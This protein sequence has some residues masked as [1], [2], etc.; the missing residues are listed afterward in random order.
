MGNAIVKLVKKV[1]KLEGFMKRRNL[2]LTDSEEE[3]PE[4]QGRKSQDDPLDSSVQGLLSFPTT[5]VKHSGR[6][7]CPLTRDGDYKRRK[8]L[9]KESSSSF[10]IFKKKLIWYE[11]VNTTMAEQTKTP[12]RLKDDKDVGAKDD[13]PTKKF[14]RRK[15]MARKGMHTSV[16]K[17]DSEDSDEVGEHEES[18]TG[19]ET[20]I[21]LVHVAIKNNLVVHC[22]NLESMD[23]YM[24][25][26]RKY[27]LSAEMVGHFTKVDGISNSPSFMY[28]ELTIGYHPTMELTF[29][30]CKGLTSPEQMFFTAKLTH[31]VTQQTSAVTTAMTAILKQFQA[32]P[33]PASVKAVEEI[34]VT[35]GGA[36]PYYQCLA[37][38][39]NT[40]PEYQDNIQGYVSAATG[41]YNQGNSCYRPPGLAN[42]TRPPGLVQQNGQNN[43]NRFSQPQG[44]NR[45]NNFNQNPTYQAPIQQNQSVPLS[46]LEKIKKIND[47]NI[48][49]QAAH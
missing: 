39:G 20:T 19:L 3:E 36:H 23:V 44:Y 10:G 6:G 1:K 16:D 26:E 18:T 38:D 35:C 22:L 7:T 43:Q 32:T 42:Q 41:N 46:E 12:K 14:G 21:N 45:G 40:F 25:S 8:R 31:A 34:C 28:K 15:Q 17:N 33:P 4:A 47:V 27:P 9:R 37:A 2:V 5:K 49:I 30:R 48:K 29:S 11:Q 13:E 24:L